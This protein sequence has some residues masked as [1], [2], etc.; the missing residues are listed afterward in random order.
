MA[1]H[2]TYIRGDFQ[3]PDALA[4]EVWASLG[5]LEGV[6]VVE[7]TVGNGAF[8]RTAPASLLGCPWFCRDL[9][10][11][12]VRQAL[13]VARSRGIEEA[14]VEHA[15]A[16]DLS[17]EC[18]VGLDREQ[19][20]LAVG[21]PPWV[22]SAGQA[23]FE[24]RNLP[25]KTNGEFGLAGLDALTGMANFDIAEAILLRL[26]SALADFHDV[27]LAFLV[28][29]SVAMKLGRRLLGRASELSFARVDAKTHFGASVD[30]G[31]FVS[32]LRSDR[33]QVAS[34]IDVAEALGGEP[35]RRAG[36]QDGRFVEDL[37]SHATSVHLEADDTVPWRQGVKHDVA[38]ILELIPTGDGGLLNGLGESVIVEPDVLC[39]L[40]KSSDVANGRQPRRVFP[41]FQNDLSGP[42]SDLASRWPLLA[43]YL[44]RHEDVFAS[45]RSRIYAGKPP[46]SIF[47]VGSYTL[48]P[49]KVVVSGFYSTPRFRVLGPSPAGRPALVDDTCY[50]LPFETEAEAHTVANYLNSAGPQKLIR[51]LSDDGAK[52]PITKALLSRV[53]IPLSPVESCV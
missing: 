44:A 3:T 19:P 8:L 31:L 6:A 16:F 12:Y 17:A 1:E 43:E 39:P 20:I 37:E 33:S 4:A 48:A 52:R 41:L 27:R 29:R 45:R 35:T 49:W 34:H 23:S 50:L 10:D 36:F 26:L 47:G 30:A 28:K 51:A 32:R 40:Y 25:K 9:N 2:Q 15:D 53:E 13:E 38:K 22:T 46:F 14:R 42:I 18:F 21:N 11:A 7:P 24:V 5:V